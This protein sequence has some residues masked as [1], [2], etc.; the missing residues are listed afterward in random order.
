MNTKKKKKIKN[1]LFLLRL[2]PTK[3]MHGQSVLFVPMSTNEVLDESE[4]QH[5][6]NAAHHH[7]ADGHL[8]G[9]EH[10]LFQSR[11][12]GI[13]RHWGQR[14]DEAGKEAHCHDGCG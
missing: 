6:G 3:K 10:S 11:M 7:G 2:L 8:L 4:N 5:E 13:G 14:D 9:V 12:S 1:C